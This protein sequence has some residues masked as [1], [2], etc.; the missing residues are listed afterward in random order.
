[1]K[2]IP[3]ASINIA[4]GTNGGAWVPLVT[5]SVETATPTPTIVKAKHLKCIFD[6]YATAGKL[7][8]G[9]V[10]LIYVP[11]GYTPSIDLPIQH[12]E[13]IMAWRGI[14]TSAE[15]LQGTLVN[16][17]SSLSRNLNSGD[18]ICYIWSGYNA[19]SG[20]IGVTTYARFSCVVR[21]N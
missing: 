6:I 21:N 17:S 2:E 12:P 1:M 5:N 16:L 7:I 13:W 20:G 15:G 14:E 11:Q 3:N 9:A 10:Y 19:G 4:T 8:N 18:S